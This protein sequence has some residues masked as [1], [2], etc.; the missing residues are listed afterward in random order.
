MDKTLTV[1]E[2][3]EELQALDPKLKVF[4]N[5][6]EWGTEPLFDVRLEIFNKQPRVVLS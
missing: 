1:K 3:I 6:S 4:I 5:D 2:L